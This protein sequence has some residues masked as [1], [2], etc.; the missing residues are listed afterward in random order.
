MLQVQLIN[1]ILSA[2]VG[3]IWFDCADKIRPVFV[4]VGL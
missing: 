1:F 4:W 2:V 3:T